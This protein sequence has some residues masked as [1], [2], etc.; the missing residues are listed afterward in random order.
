MHPDMQ[1]TPLTKNVQLKKFPHTEENTAKDIEDT[2]H[3]DSNVSDGSMNGSFLG[4]TSGNELLSSKLDPEENNEAPNARGK[5]SENL[6]TPYEMM[7]RDNTPTEP[8]TDQMS[9]ALE[10][11]RDLDNGNENNGNEPTVHW[12]DGCKPL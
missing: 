3:E 6:E 2:M 9:E 11:N 12:V 7:D 1:F 8:A 10:I 4:N 5:D